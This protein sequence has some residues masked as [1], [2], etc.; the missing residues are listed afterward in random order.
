VEANPYRERLVGQLMVALYRAGRQAEALELYERTR[1]RLGAEL[2]LQPSRELQQLAGQIVRHELPAPAPADP[3]DE[4]APADPP[5]EPHAPRRRGRRLV[6]AGLACVVAIGVLVAA[7]VIGRGDP[8]EAPVV[9]TAG[10]ALAVVDPG[11]GEL[12]ADVPVGTAPSDVAVGAGAVWVANAGSG[13]VDRIDPE[14][15]TVRQ[16]IR[17]GSSPGGVAVGEGYVWVVDSLEGTLSRIDPRSN[18]VTQTISVGNG[19][20][21]V[22]VDRGAVWVVNRDDHALVRVDPASG[23][24]AGKADPGPDPADVAVGQRA[25]WVTNRSEGTVRKLDPQ[26][27]RSVESVGVGRGPG[28]IAVG[29]GSVWV[30]NT[31]DGTVSRI[32][33]SRAVVTATIAVGEGPSGIVATDEAVRVA[34]EHD[35]ALVRI[36]PQTNDVTRMPV[37]GRPAGVA[38]GP[39]GVYV[40]VRPGGGAHV[41]GTLSVALQVDTIDTVYGESWELLGLTNDGLTAYRRI[42]GQAGAEIVPG[43]ATSVPR[44]DDGGRTYVFTLRPGL[45][46]STGAPVRPGDARRALERLFELGSPNASLYEPIV[47]ARAC[48]RRPGPCDLS[49]GIVVDER[50]RT[51]TFRLR[52]PDPDLVAKL[53]LPYAFLVPEATPSRETGTRPLPATGPYAIAG[54]VPG[55]QLRLVRNPHFRERAFRP[56]G[57]PDEIVVRVG[58]SPSRQALDVASGAVDL[59]N[60]TGAAGLETIRQRYGSRLHTNPWQTLLSCS[61]TRACPHSTTCGCGGR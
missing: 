6:A 56:A 45:R 51:I 27:G 42:G 9:S 57:A 33:P 10:N 16:T 58:L 32:D 22:A 7:T 41:G 25:L 29:G 14:T 54:Y 26:T 5:G 18:E 30:A 43:L 21:G 8:D 49:R 44:P 20:S 40:A 52:E 55:R 2:G 48:A 12:V 59:A 15:S 46:Y 4:H 28:A 36:D 37:G 34:V 24:V 39:G 19:P 38:V 47:G 13:T 60:L 53:A 35:G 31:L 11:S 61:S 17:V 1:S 23:K 50:L 3:G